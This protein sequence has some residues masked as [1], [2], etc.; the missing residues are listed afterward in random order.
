ME[1]DKGNEMTAV[2]LGE[3]GAGGGGNEALPYLPS[4]VGRE[5][6]MNEL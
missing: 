5:G 2:L 1:D 6:N 3:V 4:K